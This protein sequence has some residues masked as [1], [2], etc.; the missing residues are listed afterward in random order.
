MGALG[1]ATPGWGV[2]RRGRGVATGA[3][4]VVRMGGAGVIG[5]N[6]EE[7][8][9]EGVVGREKA[10]KGRVGGSIGDVGGGG[11]ELVRVGSGREGFL[12]LTGWLEMMEPK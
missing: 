12:A 9:C 11:I 8:A 6:R 7:G 2:G 10:V 3:E 5:L 1:V 4:G